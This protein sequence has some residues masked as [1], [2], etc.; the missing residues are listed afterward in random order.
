MAL[1]DPITNR[2]GGRVV[3]TMDAAHTPRQTA[4]YLVE[5]RGFD[6]IMPIKETIRLYR[7]WYSINITS[8][9]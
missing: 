6:Y 2:D 9:P 8:H 7:D 1:L 5:Q 4:S 3:L